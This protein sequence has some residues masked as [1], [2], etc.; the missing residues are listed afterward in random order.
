M[1]MSNVRKILAATMVAATTLLTACASG[2]T[3]YQPGGVGEA[4][5]SEQKIENNR[6]RIGFKGNSRTERDTVENYMLF[7]AAE[8]TLQSGYDTFTI[9]TRDTETDRDIRSFGGNLNSRLSYHYFSPRFGWVGAWDPFWT[10][11]TYREVTRYEAFAEIVMS[12]GP[13][14]DDPNSFD[15]KQ[16]SEN[17]AASI[18]RPAT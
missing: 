9:A 4:G 18:Q 10:P 13:K 12:R 16:V 2:P 8:L 7:R 14:G 3:P 15:A 17:L 5:Y 1:L 6:Y 11:T